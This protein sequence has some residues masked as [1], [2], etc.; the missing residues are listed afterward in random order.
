[1]MTQKDEN[2]VTW[3]MLAAGFLTMLAFMGKSMD[4]QDRCEA[5]C[6]NPNV[7]TPF[8][9]LQETCF[10]EDGHG[11]WRRVDVDKVTG[12]PRSE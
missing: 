2:L 3:F 7:I 12:A 6:G 1:M 11:K 8:V 5:R 9:G 4:F 10:C